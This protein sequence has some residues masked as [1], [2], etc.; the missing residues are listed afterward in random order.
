MTRAALLHTDLGGSLGSETMGDRLGLGGIIGGEKRTRR[1]TTKSLIR[2]HNVLSI[3]DRV[4]S[5]RQ[6]STT[7][8]LLSLAYNRS[9][10][11]CVFRSPAYAMRPW[12]AP[13]P[14]YI[15]LV[16]WQ[17]SV[18]PTLHTYITSQMSSLL[19]T[20]KSRVPVFSGTRAVTSCHVITRP[21]ALTLLPGG[22]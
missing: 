18:H 6:R 5:Q 3:P 21:R 14:P 11:H 15:V 8:C 4:K 17:A 22:P 9:G 20:L 10:R 19:T 13:S 7:S 2:R 1:R 12:P 16:R